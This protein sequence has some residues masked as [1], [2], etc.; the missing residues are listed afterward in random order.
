MYYVCTYVHVRKILF[1]V[2]KNTCVCMPCI[3]N[4]DMIVFLLLQPKE[5]G[6]IHAC[7]K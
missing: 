5:Y 7:Q 6:I 1:S 3:N 2:I 4:H